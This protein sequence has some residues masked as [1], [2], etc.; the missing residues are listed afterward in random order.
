[1]VIKTPSC[2]EIY[3]D[4]NVADPPGLY[5]EL[6]LHDIFIPNISVVTSLFIFD[7]NDFFLFKSPKNV[8]QRCLV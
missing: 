6:Q 5:A 8:N 2:D 7:G 4:L 3:T 1:M